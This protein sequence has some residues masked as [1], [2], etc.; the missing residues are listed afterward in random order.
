M[1]KGDKVNDK[2]VVT[3]PFPFAKCFLNTWGSLNPKEKEYSMSTLF[4]AKVFEH[5]SCKV[6]GGGLL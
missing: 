2:R 1:L 3:S 4:W 6:A 5:S